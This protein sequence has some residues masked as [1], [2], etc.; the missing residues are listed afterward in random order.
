MGVRQPV[1]PPKP[2]KGGGASA[3]PPPDNEDVEAIGGT[4]AERQA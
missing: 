2:T 1:S 4:S 3:E